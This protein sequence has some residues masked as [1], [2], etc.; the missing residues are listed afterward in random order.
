M[1][2]K[3][4]LCNMFKMLSNHETVETKSF[5]NNLNWIIPLL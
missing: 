5:K 3:Y 2:Q 1:L 4:L